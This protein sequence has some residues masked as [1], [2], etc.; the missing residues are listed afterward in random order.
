MKKLA[1]IFF[2]V[3]LIISTYVGAAYA[4]D[5]LYEKSSESVIA[6]GVTYQHVNQLTTKGW[7]KINIVK[8]D[9]SDPDVDIDAL[10]SPNGIGTT[11]TVP[12]M[13]QKENIVASINSDY[14]SVLTNPKRIAW[15]VGTVVKDGNLVSA[16]GYPEDQ[17]GTF[18]LSKDKIPFFY[19]WNTT[20][21]IISAS[22]ESCPIYLINKYYSDWSTGSIILF[23]KNWG[24][25]S[26]G[27]EGQNKDITEIVVENSVVKEVRKDMPGVEIPQNGYVLS[28]IRSQNGFLD[29]YFSV[30]ETVQLSISSSPDYTLIKTAVGGG[31][32]LV[33]DGAPAPITWKHSGNNPFTAAGVDQANRFLYLVT[34]DG[35]QTASVGMTQ[36]E[37]AAFMQYIGCYNAIEFDGG[38][39]TTMATRMPGDGY[40]SL[41][42]TPSDGDLRSVDEGLGIISNAPKTAIQSLILEPSTPRVFNNT[43][44]TFNV[45]GCDSNLN[46]VP[47]NIPEVAWKVDGVTGTFKDNVFYPTTTGTATIT[48][49][50]R[51]AVGSY[52]VQVLDAPVTLSL[53][54][55]Q[56]H[57]DIGQ[58]FDIYVTGKDKNGFSVPIDINRV[59]WS[60]ENDIAAIKDG[61]LTI[62]KGQSGVVK[63]SI[64]NATAYAGVSSQGSTSSVIDPFE[65][66]NGSFTGY[67][68]QVTGNYS[69][70]SSIVKNGSNAGSLDFNFTADIAATKAAYL[71]LNNPISV[72]KDTSRIGLWVYSQALYSAGLKIQGSDANGNVVRLNLAD[73]LH[74]D[75]WRYVD[76]VLPTDAT[77]PLKLDR[78]YA[79]QTDQLIK[80]QGT[81]YL[82]DLTITQRSQNSTGDVAL[83]G[84]TQYSDYL[85]APPQLSADSKP[86]RFMVFGKTLQPKSLLDLMILRRIVTVANTKSDMA[87]LVGPNNTDKLTGF[88]VPCT[89]INGYNL[90]SMNNN[91]FIW[92][93]SAKG[94]LKDT[95]AAQW[96]WLQQQLAAASQSNSCFL[97]MPA[98]IDGDKGF[99]DAEEANALKDVL[100]QKL[101]TEQGKTPLIFTNGDSNSVTVDNGIRYISTVGMQDIGPFNVIQK[102]KDLK[103]ILVTVDGKNVSYEIKNLFE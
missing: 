67:P 52:T 86:F 5:V 75:G 81:I 20:A 74:W 27:N 73:N 80:D 96:P 97:F 44:L 9:L 79:V 59:T 43:S 72:T 63:A 23:D 101:I 100:S 82:D 45:K 19:F 50:Y 78:I 92:L 13:S 55:T 41:V 3:F 85:N 14:F 39:S 36:S 77:Y 4:Y 93:D 58:N 15:P 37:L 69:L 11:A 18:G 42:N 21:S 29:N 26:I 8:A 70:N 40:L 88:T 34:V 83:P 61:K 7:L 25:K 68:E 48:A 35:R 46:P 91:L 17:F 2:T 47:I 94:G 54:P 99:K 89:I 1:S 33:K 102:L 98:P 60:F 57:G 32:F 24:A 51:G 31:T 76:T 66:L 49:S 38:G 6:K 16:H 65:T 87:V 30:G 62:L 56:F 12:D 64:D 103:Y 10:F 22:G 95:N 53:Y 90:T 71:K 28:A 84:N